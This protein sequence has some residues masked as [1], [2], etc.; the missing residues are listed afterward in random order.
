MGVLNNTHCKCLYVDRVC[1]FAHAGR[2]VAGTHHAILYTSG[3]HPTTSHDGRQK[4]PGG[5]STTQNWG[6]FNVSSNR[7]RRPGVQER[8]NTITG[9]AIQAWNDMRRLGEILVDRV[10]YLDAV[11]RHRRWFRFTSSFRRHQ[12][13]IS[14]YYGARRYANRAEQSRRIHRSALPRSK[15]LK[16]SRVKGCSCHRR[17]RSTI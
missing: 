6:S 8:R 17:P 7:R 3:L 16:K 13:K 2:L 5:W 1:S 15:S 10:Q 11:M 9:H 14:P 12:S 4:L